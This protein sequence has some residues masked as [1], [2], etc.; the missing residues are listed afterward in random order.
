MSERRARIEIQRA[1]PQ[2]VV[3]RVTFLGAGMDSAAYLVDDEWA[4]RFPKRAAVARALGREIALLP[5]LAGLLPVATPRFEFVGHQAGSGLLF[6]GYRLLPGEPLTADLLA[7][8][9]PAE[10]ERLL[11]TLAEVLRGVHRFP[12]AEAVAA[13]VGR[14]STRTWVAAAWS[15][16]QAVVLPRLS[17]GEGATLARLVERFRADPRNFANR[18]TLLYADFAPEHLLFDRR[19]RR[20]VGLIDWGDL[21]IGD[22]DFDLLYLRQDYGE[23]FVRQLLA[24][25]PHAEPARL[26]AKLRVFEACDHLNTIAAARQQPEVTDEVAG[27][28]AALRAI[29]VSA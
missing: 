23:A 19:A 9:T 18:P 24:H 6:A 1:F 2:L 13:G 14:L 26:L 12:L 29:L 8:L 16:A 25:Y 11:A 5:R 7:A 3:R 20:L 17:S 27:S 21:A 15:R 10:R 28:L 4:F 22:P